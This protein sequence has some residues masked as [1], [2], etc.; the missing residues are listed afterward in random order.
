MRRVDGV[1]VYTLTRGGLTGTPYTCGNGFQEESMNGQKS[2]ETI[3]QQSSRSCWKGGI[4][5]RALY[6]PAYVSFDDTEHPSFSK[7]EG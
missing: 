5:K 1:E 4:M 3:V 7:K 2:A 6:P